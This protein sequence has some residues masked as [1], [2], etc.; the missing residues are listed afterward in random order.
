[1][2]LLVTPRSSSGTSWRPGSF[3]RCFLFLLPP[4]FLLLP[5][6]GVRVALL[7]LLLSVAPGRCGFGSFSGT[8]ILVNREGFIVSVLCSNGRWMGVAMRAGIDSLG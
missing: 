5:S 2:H 3:P 6:L 8:F 7:C 1:M 4:F